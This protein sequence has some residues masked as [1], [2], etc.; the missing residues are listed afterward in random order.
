MK[1]CA[2]FQYDDIQPTTDVLPLKFCPLDSS[3]LSIKAAY[4]RVSTEDQK[5]AMQKAA[6]DKDGCAIIF[7]E[8]RTGT[9]ST[10]V[11]GWSW[12]SK[13]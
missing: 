3:R 4:A 8:K 13:F 9:K 11:N 7:E 2:C 12:H 10:I 5:L 6:L 1:F